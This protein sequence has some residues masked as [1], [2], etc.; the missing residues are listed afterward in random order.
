MLKTQAANKKNLEIIKYKIDQKIEVV[1]NISKNSVILGEFI[2]ELSEQKKTI[3]VNWFC[4]WHCGLRNV[5][6]FSKSSKTYKDNAKRINQQVEELKLAIQL[7]TNK[8]TSKKIKYE[9]VYREMLHRN[10]ALTEDLLNVKRSLIRHLEE[11]E[12]QN[13]QIIDLNETIMKLE[14]DNRSLLSKT[15]KI[16]LK[17]LTRIK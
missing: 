3:S 8:S 2:Q 7:F 9:D 13:A 5:H 6:S 15:K 16:H 12:R 11:Y 1:K 10:A 14:Q 4:R 17:T